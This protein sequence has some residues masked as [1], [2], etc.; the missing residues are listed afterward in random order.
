M[1]IAFFIGLSLLAVQLT[2]QEPG[3]QDTLEDLVRS[4]NE[5]AVELFKQVSPSVQ[6]NM[7]LSP[8][9][10]SAALAMPLSGAEGETQA[11]MKKALRLRMSNDKINENF[12]ALN[13]KLF[14][15]L[16][17]TSNELRF[18][19]ADSL[20]IQSKLPINAAFTTKMETY[21]RGLF[22]R[23]DF[24]NQVETS[25][26]DINSWVR[27]KTLG[28]IPMLFDKGEI[29]NSTRMVLVNTLYLKARWAKQFSKQLTHQ[30]PFFRDNHSTLSALMMVDI[31]EY[32]YLDTPTFSIILLPY[33][34]LRSQ[35]TQLAM[36]V[37]L[38]HV[39]GKLDSV[40]KEITPSAFQTWMLSLKKERVQLILPKFKISS[41]FDLNNY[42]SKM[43][44]E[45][46]FTD[47]ADFSGIT[48]VPLKIS[49]VKQKTVI[50]V[51]E[52]GTEAVASTAV[53]MSIRSAMQ[54]SPPIRFT[55]DHPFAYLIFDQ[56]TGTIL[57]MGKVVDP[58][59]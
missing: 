43:G 7:C 53:N 25:R 33:L 47:K 48:T 13:Q 1:K 46:A 50:D 51:N 16:S 15:R 34:S 39:N 54:E 24:I 57:F 3:N 32:P 2:A 6:Q 11:Q 9:S 19:Q 56:G 35:N 41:S 5:F 26:S 30:E 31:D 14:S 28:K 23:V 4:N 38:P 21:Y 40:L 44:M 17:E 12:A 22:R 20:W 18:I 45:D 37:L 55:A 58:N 52:D 8:Y 10:V 59:N 27:E 49:S 36:V 29:T 42:L